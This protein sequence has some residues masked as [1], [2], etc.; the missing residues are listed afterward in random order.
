MHG[1]G[2]ALIR[3]RGVGKRLAMATNDI[4]I[5]MSG[6]DTEGAFA[7]LEYTLHPGGVSP[8]PHRHAFSELYYVLDGTLAVQIDGKRHYGGVGATI[9]VSAGTI[10]AFDVGRESS[11]RFLLLAIP[12]GIE[13]YF[14]ELKEEL[15]SLSSGRPDLADLGFRIAQLS[16][17][18]GIE[19]VARP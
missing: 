16:Q 11:V 6:E 10:H 15:A 19:P 13:T 7:L 3:R 2:A 1:R 4:I 8:A 18:H 14:L 5:K 9:Y 17:K 12:A